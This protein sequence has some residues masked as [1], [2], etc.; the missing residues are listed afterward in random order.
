MHHDLL[1]LLKS[2][3]FLQRALEQHGDRLSPTDAGRIRKRLDRVFLDILDHRSTDPKVTIA[4]TR[5]LLQ[6]LAEASPDRSAAEAMSEACRRQLE[7]L[8]AQFTKPKRSQTPAAEAYRGLDAL[9]D[10]V[11]IIDTEYRYV[12]TNAANAA[13]HGRPANSFVG[14]PN[15]LITGERYFEIANKPR[16]DASFAGQSA[17]FISAHPMGDP[18]K[19]SAVS[20]DPVRDPDGR[21]RSCLV[22]CRDISSIPI[23]P[24]LITPLP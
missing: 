23:P 2:H 12:F 10:R 21:I 3:E 24:E 22:A 8:E 4:Q 6:C 17:R 5:F 20:I 18:S 13:Y 14:S 15:W 9:T 16:F 11:A 19:L 7:R 1:R